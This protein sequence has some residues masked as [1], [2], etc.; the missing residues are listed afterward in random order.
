MIDTTITRNQNRAS[1]I[2]RCEATGRRRSRRRT[3]RLFV[4]RR[5]N[6]DSLPNSLSSLNCNNGHCC[7][8]IAH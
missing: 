8:I 3:R 6:Q 2:S 5:F 7:Y 1:A 4:D